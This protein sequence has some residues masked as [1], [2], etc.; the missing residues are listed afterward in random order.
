ME[1]LEEGIKKEI[2]YAVSIG[3]KI[4]YFENPDEARNYA[5][6]IAYT[7]EG[8]AREYGYVTFFQIVKTSE[9]AAIKRYE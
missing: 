7:Y 5:N 4:R 9:I 6:H 1:K 2:K 3:K 8:P